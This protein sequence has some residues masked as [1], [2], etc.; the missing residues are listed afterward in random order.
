MRPSLRAAATL[1]TI[2][3]AITAQAVSSPGQVADAR[4]GQR[5]QVDVLVIERLDPSTEN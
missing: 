2:F 3:G 4:F 5:A 1:S